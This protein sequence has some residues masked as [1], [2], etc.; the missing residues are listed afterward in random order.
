MHAPLQIGRAAI[1]TDV[2]VDYRVQQRD[3]LLEIS[4]AL[5]AQ[6]NLD[7]LLQLVLSSATKM[8]SGQ[9]GLIGLRDHDGGFAIRASYGLSR[10]LAPYFEPLLT[11]IPNV[12]DRNRFH[13][14]GLA[15]KL[16]HV[17]RE[18]GL[19]LEQVVALPMAIGRDV[20]GVLYVFRAYGARFTRDDRQILGSF[21]DQA[22]IAVQNAQLYEEISQEKNRLDAILENTADGV[23]ILDATHRIVVF[24]RALAR[25]TGW[26]AGEVLGEPHERVFRWARLETE[27]DL[28]GAVAGG[29]PLPAARPLYV[30]GDLRRRQGG[31]VSVG[32]TYAPL[33]DYQG[34]L[35]NIICNVRDITRFREADELKSTF[36]S[37]V[38]H[39][40]KTPV[41]LIKGYADTLL[42]EDAHWDQATTKESLTVIVE[43]AERLNALINDLLDASR[44]Q[45][46]GLSLQFHDVA[47]DA[48]ARRV[49]N[50]FRTQ[51]QAHEIAVTF[52]PDFPLVEAD[53]D[54]IEQV[55]NNL[56]SNA[57]KYAPR[58]RIE[59]TGRAL[60]TEVV[61]S[62]T[63]QGAGLP[64]EE[65]TRVFERF[66]RG[67]QAQAQATTGAGL[68]LYLA[69]A[70][71]EAHGGRIR[72]DST[73]G[74]GAVFSFTLPRQ[75]LNK[76]V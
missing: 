67:M 59:I 47:L 64:P 46:G 31:A 73:P 74:E 7:E 18:L 69:R 54:R 22:A 23:M 35:V 25:L 1:G 36:I 62:V 50:R 44:L 13:I 72:L 19:P 42:R 27:L 33:L 51:T 37:V 66:Y 38:S 12:V 5:T 29:W 26:S 32:V 11:D 60:P 55:L 61:I 75:Q 20:I 57:I 49:A 3:Y 15:E 52:P 71:V 39:E 9:A 21:A 56:V 70:I 41:A 10:Q 68:G 28:A 43:E 16:G 58:G 65:Q 8:L 63:D 40:L 76:P 14:Q 48:V 6:L 30:E 24:N 34:R 45:A 2:L 53:P 4:R 17:V